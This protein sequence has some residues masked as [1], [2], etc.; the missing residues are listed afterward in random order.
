MAGKKKVIKTRDYLLV[1]LI[2]GATK[3]AV[4]VDRKKKANKL[5]CRITPRRSE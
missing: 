3:A 1:E 4:H 5:K 2:N